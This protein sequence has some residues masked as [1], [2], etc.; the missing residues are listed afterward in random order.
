M[1]IYSDKQANKCGI[2]EKKNRSREQLQ[3]AEKVQLN[4][5]SNKYGKQSTLLSTLL[6]LTY[7][8]DFSSKK[9]ESR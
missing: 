2:F 4:D 8:A 9:K 1:S 7:F 3:I 5:K 6:H